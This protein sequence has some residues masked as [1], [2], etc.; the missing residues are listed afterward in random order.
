MKTTRLNKSTRSTVKRVK[1]TQVAQDYIDTLIG[2]TVILK[3]IPENIK[4]AKRLF[5]VDEK[6]KVQ[7]PIRN[8]INSLMG[9]HL[10]GSDGVVHQIQFM[11][12]TLTAN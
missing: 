10:K 5:K 12:F 11:N 9:V 8:N 7:K 2:R 1:Y 6:Y 4:R 3:S